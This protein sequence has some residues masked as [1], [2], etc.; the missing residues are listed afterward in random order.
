M[1]TLRLFDGYKHTSPELADVVRELQGKLVEQGFP[2]SA[3]GYFGRGTEATVLR[4]QAAMGLVEDGI[5]GPK[6]WAAL[7]GSTVDEGVLHFETTYAPLDIPLQRAETA[8]KAYCA[9]IR[10]A[11][12]LAGVPM[13]VICG[14]GT[15]ESRWGLILRPPGAA[16]SGDFIRRNS[17]TAHRVGDLPPDGHGFGRGL[18]QIDYD[19][20][21]FAR[22]DRWKDPGLNIAYGATVLAEGM[23]WGRRRGLDGIGQL[24]AALAAYNCGARNVGRA[25]S[26]GR[27]VD[28]YTSHRDYSRD[29]ISI[30]GWF[31]LR[32]W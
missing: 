29:V 26:A 3:D 32:G 27:D 1:T 8:A 13:A 6:T 14:I 22:A 5:V 17:M 7:D 12:T 25:L 19:A 24:R 16:G 20:H 11:A 15:R 2:V 23:A 31:Q 9:H 30:S 18:M 4:F 21:E 10:T 28:Y